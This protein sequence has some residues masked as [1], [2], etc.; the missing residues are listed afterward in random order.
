MSDVQRFR[1]K[2]VVVEAFRWYGGDWAILDRTLGNNWGRADAKDIVWEHEDPDEVVV[3][4]TAE[5]CWIP[6]P[7]GHWIIRGLHGEFYP[8]DPDI[9]D[10]TYEPCGMTHVKHLGFELELAVTKIVAA[11]AWVPEDQRRVVVK[12]IAPIGL[13]RAVADAFGWDE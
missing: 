9:F 1:K 6:V 7:V 5:K 10:L 8:C 2:P 3:Y 4:N 11:L 12:H 13:R